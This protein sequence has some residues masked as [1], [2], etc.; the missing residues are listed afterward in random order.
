MNSNKNA[1]AYLEKNPDDINW[2]II[3]MNSSAIRIL[4][5]NLEKID[6]VGVSINPNAHE[7]NSI[8]ITNLDNKF[9]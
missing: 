5:K 8:E 1:I 3:S 4:E 2:E 6:W 9:L 7:S